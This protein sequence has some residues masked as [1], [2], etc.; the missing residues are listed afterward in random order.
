MSE[1]PYEGVKASA[2]SKDR[3]EA[4]GAPVEPT[5]MG[6][7]GAWGGRGGR[8]RRAMCATMGKSPGP[9]IGV[10]GLQR[11]LKGVNSK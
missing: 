8:S 7:R 6:R 5:A 11:V 9:G 4:C 3:K 2:C 10:E 1:K